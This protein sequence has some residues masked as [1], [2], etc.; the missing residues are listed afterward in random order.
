M[1]RNNV[2]SFYVSCVDSIFYVG[3]VNDTF[4]KRTVHLLDIHA[5]TAGG[6]RLRIGINH[7]YRLLKRC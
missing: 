3:M 4:V 5:Q 2:Q 7:Q 1:A 6:I